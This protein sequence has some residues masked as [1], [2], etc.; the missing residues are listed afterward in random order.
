[1]TKSH[2]RCA[3]IAKILVLWTTI[4]CSAFSFAE[5]Q[6]KQI[7]LNALAEGLL[8]LELEFSEHVVEYADK[9]QY[10]PHQ[11]IILVP[12][13]SSTLL[14]NPVVIEQGNVLN[15][16]AER[17]DLGLKI[18]I[19]LDELVPYQITQTNNSLIATFGLLASD[20]A[21]PE[22]ANNT[23]DIDTLVLA[24]EPTIVTTS[25]S[26]VLPA[27]SVI[28]S[29]VVS[30]DVPAATVSPS[31]LVTKDGRQVTVESPKI[32]DILPVED[33]EEEDFSGFVNQV[34]G[35]DFRTGNDGSGKLILT[36]KNSS[37]A[38]DIQRKGNKLIAE[39]H[40]TAIL[41]KLLYI[42][43][44]ADFGTPVT[45]IET[46]HD[47]GVTAFELDVSDDFTYRY[48]QAD[49]IFVIEITKQD[50]DEKTNKYQGQAISLNFQD[51]PVRTVLQ[52]IADFNEF[53]LVTTD[54]VNG[55]ITLRLDSVPWEQALDI[56]MK[57]KGLSKQL[58]GNVLMVAPSD[59]LAA[60]ER[61]DLV[62]KKEVEGLAELQSEF[63]QISF[64]K[65][66]D[67]AKLLAQK[68]SSLLS[69][70]GSISFDER[71]NTVLIKDTATAIAN[72]RRIVDVL[73][74]PVRQ[75][76]IEARMVSVVDN[77]DDEL[78][79]RWGL[80]GS[81]DIGSG[82]GLSSGSIEG[83]DAFAGGNV[84]A[85]GDRLNVNLPV[86][87]PAGS[88]AFQ[89][90]ELANGQIL[91]LELSALEAEQ[92]AEVIA[93]PRITTTDQKSAYIE[94]GTEIPYVESS[95]SGATTIAFK[96]AVLGLQVTPHITPDN[97]IILDLKINQDTRG[98]DVKTVGGEAVSID[99]QVISTQVLVENGETIVL[100]G[101][102][103]HEIKKIVTKVPVLGDIPWLG[104][105]FRSTKNI[106]QKRELLIFVTPKVVVDTL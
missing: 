103:K 6:L 36:M 87:S 12:D 86:A 82:F 95:S 40:S 19:A 99:T 91:D 98:D 79:I 92:K 94:Q 38:V 21:V 8:E 102:F 71:T 84:P 56:V 5:P 68:D 41:K 96:K 106:N 85:I 13:A 26:A 88:I 4:L 44:V 59:E 46:F 61:R 64:A 52:L 30:L 76:V 60:L 80:S 90:A 20:V 54:S 49:N 22:I 45:A 1:M 100:G 14:L 51:I 55:N 83:N 35:I 89:I 105:L 70:R 73:D 47:E 75:V 63:I 10:S 28:D 93:S 29:H 2:V 34:R 57:V 101:I 15:V 37:M 67:I 3:K 31:L 11:L 23:A 27:A 33:N 18:T 48:D 65:A 97:K 53:N 104:V 42:L 25:N 66:A 50:P 74:I 77:L 16:A 39:F 32:E 72:V 9:L 17:V 62:S 78:G 43:D 58:E 69:S 7:H 24:V 81:T